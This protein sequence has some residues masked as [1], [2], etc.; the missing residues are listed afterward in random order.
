MKNKKM[1][2]LIAGLLAALVVVG[3]VGATRTFAQ[4]GT[5][6]APNGFGQGPRGGHGFGLGQEELAAA[7]KVFGMTTDELSTALYNGN[8]LQELATQK[9]VDIQKV[10]DAITTAHREEMRTQIQQ[11]V[12]AG[13]MT[14]AKADWLL[15]GLDKG[16]LDGPGFGFGFGP[17][18][19][20]GPNGQPGQQNPSVTAT[21]QS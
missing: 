9:G 17:H 12:T 20:H 11:A 21:P 5:P 4:S 1:N 14:Q 2:I 19:G 6:T 3:I 10:N 7:A 16:Y 8:T 13:T 15:Q 18:G